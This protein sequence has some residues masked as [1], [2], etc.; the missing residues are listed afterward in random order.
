MMNQVGSTPSSNRYDRFMRKR[1]AAAGS[2][3]GASDPVRLRHRYETIFS[4]NRELFKGARV[5]DLMSSSGF[6]SLAALDAG[7]AHVVGV[8]ASPAP[9][10]AAKKTFGE[11]GVNSGSY[12]FINSE[13]PAALR[14]FEPKAFDVILCHG[15]LEQSDP[16]FFFQQLSRLQPKHVVLDTR[17]VQGKGPIVRLRLRS[18]DEARQKAP[19]RYR[20][21]LS[22]PNHDLIT[23]FCDYFQ[24][25]WRLIDWKAT[26]I[27]DWTGI[28]DYEQDRRRTYVLERAAADPAARA[29]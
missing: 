19:E 17:I 6:W 2:V 21:I 4:R 1:A 12:R 9:I 29:R 18:G 23:F 5:L 10:E 22:I 11:Y 26:G 25:R 27:T 20:S 28:G 15:F 7:A 8:E 14:K 3:S 16:R 24:L 13:I